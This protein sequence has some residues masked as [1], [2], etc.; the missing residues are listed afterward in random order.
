MDLDCITF[1]QLTRNE[2]DTAVDWAAAEGWNPGLHDA[3]VFWETDPEGFIGA[4]L[5]GELVGTGS[6]V[7]YEGEYG[8]MGFF[9]VRPELRG[10]GIGTKLWFHRRDLLKSRLKPGAVIGMD[11]VFDMQNWYAKG[12]F[13]FYHR[14]LR[15]EGVG[16]PGHPDPEIVELSAHSFE[17]VAAFDLPY[18]GCARDPF[19]KRWLT[20]PDSLALGFLRDGKLVGYGVIRRCREGCKIGPLFAEDG[21]VAE[22]LLV[23]LRTFGDEVPVWLDIP[24]NN[25]EA[26]ALADRHGMKEVFGCARMYYGAAPE[27]PWDK[28]FGI[29]TFELG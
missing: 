9:I 26:V 1:R 27:L 6:I 25:P 15:M 4:E 14:N 24:E 12:G 18:F 21:G 10:S 29:S 3:D 16:A 20:L 22:S 28:I 2:L 17:K 19:L 11:G 23:A 5:N 13:E 7:S 8:F